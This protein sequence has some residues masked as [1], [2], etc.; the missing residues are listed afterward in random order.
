MHDRQKA[1]LVL[2]ALVTCMAQYIYG[3]TV[4][5]GTN[6]ANSATYYTDIQSAVDACVAGDIVLVSNGVYASGGRPAP[7]Y[8]LSNRVVVLSNITVRSVS[9]PDQAIIVGC[10]PTGDGFYD[11]ACR[12]VTIMNGMLSGF[13][14][15]NGYTREDGGESDDGGGIVAYNSS[16][17]NCYIT[18]NNAAA[19][20]GGMYTAISTI[21]KC[22]FSNNIANN[23]GGIAALSGS[24]VS[25]CIFSNNMAVVESGGGAY[26]VK[27]T[28]SDCSFVCNNSSLNGGGVFCYFEG[29]IIRCR[30]VGNTAE[31]G[32]GIRIDG[33]VVVSN[34]FVLSN[35]A[36]SGGGLYMNGGKA[37]DCIVQNNLAVECGGGVSCNGGY[38]RNSLIYGNTASYGGGVYI[39]VNGMFNDG[40]SID[41]CIVT[42]NNAFVSGGGVYCNYGAS[43]TNCLIANMNAASNGA[44]VF[45]Y[46][47]AALYSCTISANDA[48]ADGGGVYCD[49]GLIM[50]N[51]II[52]D[53]TAPSNTNWYASTNATFSYCCMTPAVGVGSISDS[54]IFQQ[55]GIDFRLIEGSPCIDT[56]TNRGWM[57]S[58]RD[59]EGNPRIYNGITD[60]GCYEYVPEPSILIVAIALSIFGRTLSKS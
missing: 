49:D 39:G 31:F 1:A 55:P 51:C 20:G 54:P 34:C 33:D 17:S 35:I 7:G 21:R 15:S 14:L 58:M 48:L 32:A 43:L 3:K 44:G 60:M 4:Y 9:G 18:C 37:Y 6:G 22:I 41:T 8:T 52:Q 19:M 50:M 12:C 57:I 28:M 11:N 45:C 47:N 25:D 42:G 38:V 53:N 29:T 13:T 16:V 56:G 30:A 40:G 23:G 26:C 24:L 27:S 5:V 46:G 2:F 59:I 10:K 36:S